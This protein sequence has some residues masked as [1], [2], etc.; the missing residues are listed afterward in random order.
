MNNPLARF[1]RAKRIGL[2]ALCAAFVALPSQA[3]TVMQD[4]VIGGFNRVDIYIPDADS[5]VYT[6]DVVTESG[7]SK[8][9]MILLHGC[10]QSNDSYM[11]AN[12][13][14]AAEAMGVVIAV[15]E[16]TNPA[17]NGCWS[18][19]QGAISRNTGDYQNLIS[20][21]D[22]MSNDSAF[23]VDGNQVYIAGLNSGGT[24]AA[25][26][27]CL[28]PDVFK[29]VVMSA[30]PVIGSGLPDQLN[31]CAGRIEPQAY[32]SRCES[33]AGSYASHLADQKMVTAHAHN[34]PVVADC[35]NQNNAE[36]FA[37]AY[38]ANQIV[39]INSVDDGGYY[40]AEE[41]L[42]S[43][44]IE[45]RVSM[46]WLPELVGHAWSA[47]TG[48]SGN[49]I[50]DVSINL[51]TY[52]AQFFAEQEIIEPWP[53]SDG[54]GVLDHM[55]NCPYK[56]NPDQL[57]SDGNGIGDACEPEVICEEMTAFNYY[58]KVGG[59]AYSTGNPLLPD[60]FANGSD[61][62]LF[63]STWGLT[64]LHT[65]DGGANWQLGACP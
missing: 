37:Q 18:Y 27:A 7:N 38:G 2:S 26:T 35:Y 30:A 62:S 63:G 32:Q 17:G 20:L 36:G 41:T 46:V 61:D 47:G 11:N 13:A 15:P 43:D 49:Y 45:N 16:V 33:Y 64:T 55:D 56:P 25:Q 48:A 28:A 1:S 39:E 19:W 10:T 3:A 21:A 6:T 12:L 51:L 14:E 42:Y 8:A 34:D 31:S 54:D 65:L 24:F 4:V 44:G 23:S 60:Y 53:D 29:G 50:S 40:P 59:R 5:P 57:D 22:V 9:L 52:A 58:H